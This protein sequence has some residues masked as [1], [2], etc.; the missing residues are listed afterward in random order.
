VTS[1]GVDADG[2]LLVG[3]LALEGALAAPP[4]D[5][6]EGPDAADA[7]LD[8][9]EGLDAAAA[10]P[11]V[12]VVSEFELPPLQP[13][14]TAAT[15]TAKATAITPTDKCPFICA[16]PFLEGPCRVPWRLLSAT[17]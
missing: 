9:A 10:P 5:A 12:E 7:G 2:V 11:L 16:S 17:A 4:D 6:A 8:A 15:A 14:M 13:P 3:E 1:T